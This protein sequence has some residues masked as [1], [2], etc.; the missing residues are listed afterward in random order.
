MYP[1]FDRG[2]WIGGDVLEKTLTWNLSAFTGTGMEDDNKY[3]DIDDHKDYVARLFYSPFKN[4]KDSFL[5]GLHLC[6]QG[7][8][9]KQS[10]PTKRFEQKGYSAAIRDDKF[11]T[12]Q[13]ESPGRG[14][15]DSRNRW[16][17]E[18]Q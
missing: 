8:L 17:A 5:E 4:Q 11:W 1:Y 15:I 12:W 13:T 2:W 18:V 3:G 10:V 6:V 7:S 9:G 16:G 14:Q